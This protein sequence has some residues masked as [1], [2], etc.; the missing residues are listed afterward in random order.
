[1]GEDSLI[2]P[3]DITNL[4]M[5]LEKDTEPRRTPT[6][7][8]LDESYLKNGETNVMYLKTELFSLLLAL[9][10]AVVARQKIEL[11]G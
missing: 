7:I 3:D 8:F 1:M 5:D 2:L 6:P 11:M 9:L 4:V 10:F